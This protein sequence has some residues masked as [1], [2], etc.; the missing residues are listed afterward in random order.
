VRKL[1]LTALLALALCAPAFGFTHTVTKH[2]DL[3]G[4]AA[5]ETVYTAQVD[6]PGVSDEFDP[7]Q[8]HIS[9]T[10]GG[11]TVDQ[12]V[13]GEEDGVVALKLRRIDTRRGAEVF[14]DMRSGASA[15]Q[16]ET[17]VVA[18][19]KHAGTPCRKARYLFKYTSRKP[20]HA[21]RGT[22]GEVSSFEVKV[23]E[24]S[25]RYRGKEIALAEVFTRPGEPL[26]CGSVKKVSYWRYS[27]GRDKYVRYKTKIRRKTPTS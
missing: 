14:L 21:P 15:R 5:K 20:T 1:S 3:D 12:K 26:C 19:R 7:T 8:I 6:L 23:G 16:G 10:C 2:G 22:N 18:W 25:R 11:A 13:S 24:R 9:D 27:R 17:R 4:D